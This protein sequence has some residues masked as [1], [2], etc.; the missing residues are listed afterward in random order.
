MTINESCIYR[1]FDIPGTYND[2]VEK[3][4]NIK[5]Q[6]IKKNPRKSKK[7]VVLNISNL[8]KDTQVFTMEKSQVIELLQTI[9]AAQNEKHDQL[10][11]NSISKYILKLYLINVWNYLIDNCKYFQC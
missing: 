8:D 6:S 1:Y 10:F 2:A 4:C 11:N 7:N 5:L 3:L 9:P